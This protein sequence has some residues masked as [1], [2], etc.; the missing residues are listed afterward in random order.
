[1]PVTALSDASSAPNER[2]AS[3]CPD[4]AQPPHTLLVSIWR[5]CSSGGTRRR[6]AAYAGQLPLRGL[7]VATRVHAR[8]PC[9]S[10]HHPDSPAAG[11]EGGG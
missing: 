2:T 4:L 1:M 6:D 5:R 11:G 9:P 8:V 10:Q 7:P 3:L